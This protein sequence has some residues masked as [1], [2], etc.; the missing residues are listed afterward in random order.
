MFVEIKNFISAMGLK[1]THIHPNNYSLP[2][3]YGNPTAVEITLERY[4]DELNGKVKL[5]NRLDMKCNPYNIDYTLKFK[6]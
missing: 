1:L 3:K 6:N 5:P 4:T 2:D